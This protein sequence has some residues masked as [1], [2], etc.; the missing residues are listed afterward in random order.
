MVLTEEKDINF[1]S[2]LLN[3]LI[4]PLQKIF[5]FLQFWGNSIM[6]K[7]QL[8]Q[9]IEILIQIFKKQILLSK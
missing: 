7:F 3:R 9:K 4:Q 8:T 6:W 5:L 1:Y 2:T